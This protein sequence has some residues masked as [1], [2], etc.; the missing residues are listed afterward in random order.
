MPQCACYYQCLVHK[1]PPSMSQHCTTSPFP[2]RQTSCLARFPSS[3]T[4]LIPSIRVRDMRFL[5]QALP[6]NQVSML[7]PW[8]C[9]LAITTTLGPNVPIQH[10]ETLPPPPHYAMIMLYY[11]SQNLRKW[12][13]KSNRRIPPESIPANHLRLVN[14]AEII[15]QSNAEEIH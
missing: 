4:C 11:A 10:S 3:S 15:G 12:T 13:R 6:G 1:R 7:S 8:R 9:F 5:R 14:F 2:N